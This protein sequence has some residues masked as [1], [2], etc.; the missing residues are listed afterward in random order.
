M[1]NFLVFL[2]SM[3]MSERTWGAK[4]LGKVF[5]VHKIYSLSYFCHQQNDVVAVCHTWWVGIRRFPRV[6]PLGPAA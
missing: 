6:E 2:S 5:M 1:S 3:G 4:N